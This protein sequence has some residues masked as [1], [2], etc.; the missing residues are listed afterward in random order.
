M[1]SHNPNIN[2]TR[3]DQ[4]LGK[5]LKT[6]IA[7]RNAPNTI[8]ANLLEAAAAQTILPAGKVSFFRPNPPDY[9][10]ISFREFARATAFSLQ[11]G[12]SNV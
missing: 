7:N 4:V 3:F 11:A 2:D 10:E 5:Y 9:S 6:W 1:S 12:F 8:R